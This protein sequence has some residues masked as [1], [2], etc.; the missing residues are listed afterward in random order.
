MEY[1]I[2]IIVYNILDKS[3]RTEYDTEFAAYKFWV[4]SSLYPVV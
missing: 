2:T 1:D 4:E 3:C